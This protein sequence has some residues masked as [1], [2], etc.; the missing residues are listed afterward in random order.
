MIICTLP[1]S[2]SSRARSL[3]SGTESMPDSSSTAICK[4]TN[5]NQKDADKPDI[6]DDLL[7]FE[8]GLQKLQLQIGL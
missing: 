6:E 1:P 2:D 4:Q 7:A 5:I 8:I 3:R